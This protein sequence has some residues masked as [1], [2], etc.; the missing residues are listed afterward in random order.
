MTRKKKV[1]QSQDARTFL[2]ALF[3]GKPDDAFMLL[4]TLPGKTSH[5]FANVDGAVET[6]GAFSTTYD[7]YCGAALSHADRG[8]HERGTQDNVAGIVGLWADVDY[9]DPAL[10]QTKVRPPDEESARAVV[11]AMGIE[12]TIIVHSGHGL[13]AWWLFQ[14][15]WM[16]D[17]PAE[18]EAARALS[19]RWNATMRVHALAEGHWVIDAT[20][21]L[22]RV[23]RVPGTF[24]NKGER[25]PVRLL[26]YDDAHRYNPSDFD[27]YLADDGALTLLTGRRTTHIPTGSLVLNPAAQ[28]DIGIIDALVENDKRFAETWRRKRKDFTDQSASAYDMALASQLAQTTMSNQDIVNVLIASRRKHGDD[29]KCDRP[30]YYARTLSRARDDA[31]AVVGLEA[32]EERTEQ[33]EVAQ[34]VNA[35]DSSA[36]GAARRTLLDHISDALRVEIV[37]VERLACDPT[38]QWSLITPAGPVIIP[39]SDA[40]FSVS[41]VRAAIFGVTKQAIGK[42]KAGEWQKIVEAIG[43]V[44]ED[45]SLGE[46]ATDPGLARAWLVG[47]FHEKTPVP[48]LTEA[49]EAQYPYRDPDDESVYVFGDSL[50]R[51]IERARSE[52]I[53]KPRLGQVMRS[54]GCT[55]TP[56][57]YVRELNGKRS[58]RNAW[59]LPN[60]YSRTLLDA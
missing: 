1:D 29:L 10:T 42:F 31:S 60:D 26:S 9:A 19:K 24:N 55:P 54:I 22:S 49:C 39:S 37:Q 18:L 47:Y 53:S 36:V 35:S 21:D 17:T 14:E 13:Q 11:K 5:W 30:D 46:E 12:P 38:P 7:V 16:F 15:P 40:L 20:H 58:S 51:W 56:L 25:V 43:Q 28:P 44:A 41:R 8:P 2:S 59:L 6:V 32:L 52:R 48:D 33:L 3:G 34:Q 50:S 45:V 27:A 57:Y 4:W 23:M